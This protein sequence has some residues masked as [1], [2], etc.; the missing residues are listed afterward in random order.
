MDIDDLLEDLLEGLLDIFV[1]LNDS[2]SSGLKYPIRNKDDKPVINWYD[3]DE[4]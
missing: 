1:I 4:L 3:E 2:T